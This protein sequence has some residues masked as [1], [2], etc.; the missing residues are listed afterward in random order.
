M[1]INK[2]CQSKTVLQLL[3]WTDIEWWLCSADPGRTEGESEAGC[4]DHPE[5]PS[6]RDA[7]G[8][9]LQHWRG[10]PHRGTRHLWKVV[11][12]PGVIRL[13]SH[14]DHQLTSC[15]TTSTYSSEG[16]GMHVDFKDYFKEARN[17]RTA[18]KDTSHSAFLTIAIRW[19]L[20]A[21]WRKSSGLRHGNVSS[22][23]TSKLRYVL[24]FSDLLHWSWCSV[25]MSGWMWTC[26]VRTGAHSF[27][28]TTAQGCR[29]A[30]TRFWQ[31][32]LM[33]CQWDGLNRS[34]L[35][36]HL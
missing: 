27:R 25:Q 14:T 6:A 4:G 34:T 28:R 31:I 24:F 18:W 20:L 17:I 2:T 5:K 15:N 35:R 30:D 16:T 22:S 8:L 1:C 10:Q 11:W 33:K 19:L 7:G 36:V 9:L 23:L 26:L 3:L 32:A 12:V 21:F 29:G 13:K